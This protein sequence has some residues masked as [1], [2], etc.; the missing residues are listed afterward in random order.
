M[1]R[2]VQP[3]VDAGTNGLAFMMAAMLALCIGVA[4]SFVALPLV[5]WPVVLAFF[6]AQAL[7]MVFLL[8]RMTRR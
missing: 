2:Q 8:R 3:H 7:A 4:L 5:G 1:D 6:V